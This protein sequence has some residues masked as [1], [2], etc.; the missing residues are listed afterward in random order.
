MPERSNKAEHLRVRNGG[1]AGRI[2]DG[3]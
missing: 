2:R 3:R 1:K